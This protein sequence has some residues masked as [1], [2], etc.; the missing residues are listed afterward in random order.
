VG[1]ALGYEMHPI[2]W[3]REVVFRS[4]LRVPEAQLV[5]LNPY[6]AALQSGSRAIV[7]RVAGDEAV[8]IPS[9]WFGC[10][11]EEYQTRAVLFNMCTFGFSNASLDSAVNVVAEHLRIYR[12]ISL[13]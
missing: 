3:L 13:N 10:K 1:R 2:A 6:T 7:L 5:A 8:I 9:T 11:P 4:R 12:D